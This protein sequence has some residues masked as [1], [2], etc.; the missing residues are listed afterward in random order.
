[1]N[2]RFLEGKYAEIPLSKYAI[3]DVFIIGPNDNLAFARKLMLKNNISKL[4]MVENGDIAGIISL[5]DI[6]TILIEN[7][8][9]NISLDQ[10]LVKNY[11][12]RV[13]ITLEQNR[14]VK[15]GCKIMSDNNIGS[16]VVTNEGKLAGIFTPTD[17]CK[18]FND[19]P[20]EELK[21]ESVMRKEVVKINK[22]SS[23]WRVISKFKENNDVLLVEDNKK[24][25]G[26]ISLSKI[27]SL[28]ETEF[29]GKQ[30][31]YIRGNPGLEKVKVSKLAADVMFNVDLAVSSSDKLTKAVHYLL[32]FDLP[33][34]PVIDDYG[35][36]I[37][38]ISKKDIVRLM[39]E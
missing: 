22:M 25:V 39:A 27:A 20:I 36:I 14:S 16:V 30:I 33:A 3:K 23:I 18:V 11:A 28:D 35:N 26:M 2:Q 38:I 37:G 13:V 12:K 9:Q 10:L 32:N 1:M 17:A 21:V 31:K 6:A 8:K 24:I 29:F 19:N 4:V 34:L 5:R 7:Y 15:E